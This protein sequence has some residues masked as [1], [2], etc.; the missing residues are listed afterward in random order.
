M[1]FDYRGVHVPLVTPFN[2]DFSVDEKGYRTLCRHYL[3]KVKAQGL[4]PCGTTGESPTL[5]GE[6]KRR[7]IQIAVEEAG[8]KVPVMAGT[9]TNSTASTIEMTCAAEKLGA[10]ACLVVGPYYNKPTPEGMLAHFKAVAASTSLPIFIYNIPGRTGKNIDPKTVIELAE[11][12]NI[13]GLKDAAGDLNQTMQ[14]ISGTRGIKK[15]DGAPFYVLSGEDSLTYSIMAL[16]GHGTIAATAHVVGEELVEMMACFRKGDLV[17][18]REIQYR[19]L[20]M[21]KALFIESNPSPLKAVLPM[22][23]LPAGTVRLPLVDVQPASRDALRKAMAD[24]GKIR[25]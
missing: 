24:L 15:A 22:M 2:A 9:G 19:I 4:V 10:D 7:L 18:A 25:G 17:G 12:E 16:G 11:V 13:V 8:G 6:E 23:G 1:G 21:L 3:D 20:P 5:T 14:I